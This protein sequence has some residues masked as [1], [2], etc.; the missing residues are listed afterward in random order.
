MRHSCT[1]FSIRKQASCA[2]SSGFPSRF[3]NG[4]WAPSASCTFGGII[5]T[6]G[7]LKTPGRIVL[8]RTPSFIK[9]RAIGSVI[10]STPP[11]E[12]E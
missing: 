10:D 8:T 1:L 9:S 5:A 2:Y 12:A 11:F 7:V 3:G 6:I 4:T